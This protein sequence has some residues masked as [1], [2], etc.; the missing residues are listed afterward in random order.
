[1]PGTAAGGGTEAH[2]QMKTP[3]C[4]LLLQDGVCL[5]TLGEQRSGISTKKPRKA[6]G[7]GSKLY[8]RFVKVP[9][10]DTAL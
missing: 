6:V 7:A 4:D 5:K 8:G 10:R 3:V 2:T 9:P 1:M